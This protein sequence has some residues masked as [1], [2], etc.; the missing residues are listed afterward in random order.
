M[1]DA[2][3]QLEGIPGESLH[4]AHAG[5][6]DV[7]GWHWGIEAAAPSPG[8]GG[9]AGR[10]R[11]G[12]LVITHAYDQASPL[13][14]RCCARRAHIPAGALTVAAS[15]EGQHDYLRIDLHD[16]TVVSVDVTGGA[17]GVTE[18]VTLSYAWIRV[19]YYPRGSHG[20][21]GNGVAFSWDLRTNA[22]A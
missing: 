16:L 18:T 9:G 6:I 15:G 17:D 21:Q 8:G 20:E 14:E 22:I 7:W 13:L 4:Q 19:G 11:A 2:F 12:N 10:S 5:E 1:N 3:L